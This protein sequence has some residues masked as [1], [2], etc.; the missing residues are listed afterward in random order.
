MNLYENNS[1]KFSYKFTCNMDKDKEEF[2]HDWYAI[3]GCEVGSSKEIIEKAAR[4]LS[5]KHHPD[6]TTDPDATAKFL[7]IQKAKE[8]LTD[9][10]R[11]KIIDDYYTAIKK[12]EKYEEER[13]KGMDAN[14]KRFRDQLDEKIKSEQNKQRRD[15]SEVLKQE[16]KKSSKVLDEMRKKNANMMQKSAEEEHKRQ[17]QKEESYFKYRENLADELSNKKRQLKV[18][19]RKSAESESDHS[20]YMLFKQFGEVEEVELVKNKGTSAIVTFASDT[21]AELAINHFRDSNDYRVSYLYQP[22]EKAAMFT[23]QYTNSS[24]INEDIQKEIQRI[25]EL[26]AVK[27]ALHEQSDGK[28]FFEDSFEQLLNEDGSVDYVKFCAK[29]NSILEMLHTGF[30]TAKRQRTS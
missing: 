29:E 13:L 24:S 18:K 8:I 19:W 25:R 9:D 28:E 22:K 4:K 17:A 11:K 27:A 14:R 26:N 30:S 15:P 5:L 10:N 12:R 16:L 20:L 23:H 21:A 2:Q 6:K 1:K 3:L 7:L